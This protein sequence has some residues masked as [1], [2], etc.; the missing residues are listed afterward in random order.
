MRAS[1]GCGSISL[2]RDPQSASSSM[3]CAPMGLLDEAIREHLELKRRR[4]ADPAEVAR[5]QHEALDPVSDSAS[6]GEVDASSA[7]H[8]A[9]AG[10]APEHADAVAAAAEQDSA[11]AVVE[12]PSAMVAHPIA[13]AQTEPG[14]LEETA[15]LDMKSVLEDGPAQAA[16]GEHQTVQAPGV[17]DEAHDHAGEAAEQESVHFEHGPTDAPG[18]DA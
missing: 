2:V 4:G 7:E 18:L 6:S 9:E 12:D 3:V 14:L 8:S 15:E 10:V 13:G 11:P 5:E 17:W 1:G 16:S